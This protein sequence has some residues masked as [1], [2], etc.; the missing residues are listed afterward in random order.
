[1]QNYG[2]FLVARAHDQVNVADD[3]LAK[4]LAGVGDVLDGGEHGFIQDIHSVV[5]DF[6]KQ[7]VLA[8]H[9]MIKAC[10]G[11]ADGLRDIL[12]RSAVV[13]LR[14]EDTRGDAANFTELL[15]GFSSSGHNRSSTTSSKRSV[16]QKANA[17]SG[18]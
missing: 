1:M 17:G 11:E 4:L 10:L 3:G 2:D 12:H 9:V 5:L 14:V 13:T 6:V 16:A 15:P 7:A 8:A 18:F